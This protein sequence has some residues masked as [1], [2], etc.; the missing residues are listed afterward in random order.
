MGVFLESTLRDL[1][2]QR[3]EWNDEEAGK[4]VDHKFENAGISIEIT[5]LK[6]V[7]ITTKGQYITLSNIN[8]DQKLEQLIHLLTK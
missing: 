8:C 1:G 6:T 7:E 5:N 2:F 3:Y 4:I